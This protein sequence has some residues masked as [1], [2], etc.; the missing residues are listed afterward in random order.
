LLFAWAISATTSQVWA[1]TVLDF[2]VG[3][4][5]MVRYGSGKHHSG[6]RGENI[7][8]SQLF[9]GSSTVATLMGRLSFRDEGFTTARNGAFLGSAGGTLSV[10]G[11]ADLNHDAKCDKGDFKG[12]LL[13]GSFVSSK[14]VQEGGKQ[15][16][17]AQI[18]D[19]LNP[20]L[21]ALLGLP[22]TTYRG[23]L[24]LL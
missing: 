18:V 17:I 23:Q 9:Y 10:K 7:M 1:G 3:D 21:A 2:R 15:I 22:V 8:L 11:C 12:T 4:N 6:L 24:E 5:G 16:L 19:R 20:Q 13:T 14:V